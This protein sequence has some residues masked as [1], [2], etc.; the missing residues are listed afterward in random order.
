MAPPFAAPLGVVVLIDGVVTEEPRVSVFDRGFL[1][2]DAVFEALRTYEGKPFALDQHLDRLAQSMALLGIE[3]SFPTL[4]DEVRVGV[5]CSRQVHADDVYV[6][7][8]VTRGVGPLH[9]DPTPARTPCRIVICAPL[10]P[11]PASLASGV[12]MASVHAHRAADATHAA[13]AKVTAYVGNLLAYAEAK[14]RGAYEALLTTESG[15]VLEGHSS[16]FFVVKAGEVLTPP[17]SSGILPGITRSLVVELAREEGV[18]VRETILFPRDVYGADE[19][20]LTSSLREVVPVVTVDGVRVG[21][22]EPGPITL[23]L[24]AKYRERVRR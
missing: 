1:F 11:L 6:R 8:I 2:G 24:R 3:G 19:A 15:Q 21:S 16:S 4:A 13:A 5:A 18:P 9:L 12:A 14:R 20:F 23:R 10:L 17:L 7:I 22:G